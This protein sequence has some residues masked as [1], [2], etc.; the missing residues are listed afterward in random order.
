MP[1]PTPTWRQGL[2]NIGLLAVYCH[3][4]QAGELSRDADS[5]AQAGCPDWLPA[6]TRCFTGQDTHGAYYPGLFMRPA[7]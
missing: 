6:A 2:L 3:P 1:K 4:L 7:R 5:M